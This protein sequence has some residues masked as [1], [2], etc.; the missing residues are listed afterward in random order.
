M[1][2]LLNHYRAEKIAVEIQLENSLIY[3]GLVSNVD[4]G[5]TSLRVGKGKVIHIS[6]RAII[7]VRAI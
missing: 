5:I 4:N 7:T 2:E 1:S 6:T 3:S